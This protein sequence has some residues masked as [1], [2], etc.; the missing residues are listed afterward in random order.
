MRRP[1]LIID[2]TAAVAATNPAVA[3]DGEPIVAKPLPLVVLAMVAA[4]ADDADDR[5]RRVAVPGERVDGE[6]GRE[7]VTTRTRG[8]SP[9]PSIIITIII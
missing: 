3:D 9:S 8:T 6:L 1:L 7:R 5:N 2:G 4:D